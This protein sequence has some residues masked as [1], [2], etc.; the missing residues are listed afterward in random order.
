MINH[1]RNS[2]IR[3]AEFHNRIYAHHFL[4]KLSRLRIHQNALTNL[5]Q[6]ALLRYQPAPHYH[7]Q[8]LHFK[9]NK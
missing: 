5:H 9:N 7:L 2:L 3:P 6:Q 1:P 4:H 8:E